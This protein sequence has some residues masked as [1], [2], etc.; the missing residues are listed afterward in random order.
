MKK[1]YGSQYVCL[2]WHSDSVVGTSFDYLFAHTL[3]WR[4]E[5]CL[6]ISLYAFMTRTLH[7]TG[8]C[9]SFAFV[10][11]E[12]LRCFELVFFQNLK[13]LQSYIILGIL[14]PCLF[15]ESNKLLS[16]VCQGAL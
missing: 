7:T 11:H 16:C 6:L 8:K 1:N 12:D 3:N 10:A 9:C 15:P 5:F 13:Q 4:R 2:Q 14:C